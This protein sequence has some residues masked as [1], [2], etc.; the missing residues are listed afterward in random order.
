MFV[1]VMHVYELRHFIACIER[2]RER[3]CEMINGTKRE[4]K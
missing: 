2:E 4:N 3:E 1:Y